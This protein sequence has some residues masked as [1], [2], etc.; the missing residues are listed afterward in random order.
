MFIRLAFDA[1]LSIG[2]LGFQ[3]RKAT[4]SADCCR[5]ER[6]AQQLAGQLHLC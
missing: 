2:P 6:A 5:L 4:R 3:D 1:S